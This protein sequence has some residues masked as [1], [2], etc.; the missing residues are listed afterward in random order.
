MSSGINPPLL[1]KTYCRIDNKA[2]V[3]GLRNS[4]LK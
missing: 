3:P 1:G 4:R 2:D